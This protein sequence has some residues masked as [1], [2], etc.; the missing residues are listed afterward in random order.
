MDEVFFL[1]FPDQNFCINCGQKKDMLSNGCQEILC[2][3]CKNDYLVT[4]VAFYSRF[5]GTSAL[6]EVFISLTIVVE[7]FVI[8]SKKRP[9]FKESVL[10]IAKDNQYK[11]M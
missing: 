2:L 1:Y 9:K 6:R 7:F 4:Y 5:A 10:H 11:F 3:I 8:F